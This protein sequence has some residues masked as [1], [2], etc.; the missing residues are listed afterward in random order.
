MRRFQTLATCVALST[1][2]LAL[3][4]PATPTITPETV[5]DVVQL[6]D[7]VGHTGYI[8][9]V[10]FSPD[11]ATLASVGD[12]RAVR[13]WDLT[14]GD[15]AHVFRMPGSAAYINALSFSPDGRLLASPFGVWDLESLVAVQTWSTEVMHLAFSPDGLML[16]V[17]AELV[18]VKLLDTT[19]WEVI[20]TFESLRHIAPSSD[21]S[22]G[23]EFSPDGIWLV[24]G[25]LNEGIARVWNV[26]MGT[27]VQTLSVSGA[28]TDVH[29]VAFTADGRLLAAGGHGRSVVLFCMEDGSVERTL[30]LGE[31][32]M[33][34]DFSPDG[35]MLAI[36][37]EGGVSL[38]NVET[39][40]RLRTLSHD[41]AVL[42]V[43][44][45]SDGRFLAC[46]VRGGHVVVWGL[47]E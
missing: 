32:T 45:S 36:S 19:T 13:L 11:G 37:R 24:D 46:G 6:F 34:L 31:G 12:D 8:R 40:R 42:P 41:G 30:S 26:E 25:T 18:P 1:L 5:Y 38:W 16:A 17:G 22:F 10:V 3:L 14:A 20:R 39:G 4:A 7:F 9:D 43:A 35:R 33:S 28:G 23:F 27:F 29:D 15:E 2:A 47:R 21:A 44:F